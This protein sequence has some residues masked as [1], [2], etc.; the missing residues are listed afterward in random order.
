MEAYELGCRES[1][2]HAVAIMQ[3]CL[4]RSWFR[5]PQIY[6]AI[7]GGDGTLNE[8]AS[9]VPYPPFPVALLPAGTANVVARELGLP[10]DPIRALQVAL[11]RV[12]RPVDLGELNAGVRRFL[13]VAGIGFDAYVVA[14]V[15]PALKKK[16][17]MAAY[18][19]AIV[20]GLRRYSF[21]GVSSCRRRPKLYGDQLSRLQCQ[22]LRRRSALLPRG[23]YERRPAGYSYPGG[24]AQTCTWML[25]AAGMA[26]KCGKS[27]LDSPSAGA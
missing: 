21:P 23:R 2:Q 19:A 26:R 3:V 12:V 17:G 8:V 6:S 7:C 4:L 24:E 18:A 5:I 15:R 20:S 13:F 22:K 16:L 25:F 10:L 11:N 27:G 14:N 1:W 9:R